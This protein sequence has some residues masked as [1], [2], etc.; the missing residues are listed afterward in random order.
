[1]QPMFSSYIKGLLI[2]HRQLCAFISTC[3]DISEIVQYIDI[4][5]KYNKYQL[6]YKLCDSTIFDDIKSTSTLSV[7]SI[8]CSTVTD[9]QSICSDQVSYEC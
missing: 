6:I 3:S 7:A 1:M 8:T 5:S 2:R 4:I 9:A